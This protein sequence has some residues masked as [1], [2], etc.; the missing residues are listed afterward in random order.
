MS[1]KAQILNDAL[2]RGASG[3]TAREMAA[4]GFKDQV[5]R[6]EVRSLLVGHH[7]TVTDRYRGGDRVLVLPLYATNGESNAVL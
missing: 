7:L 5:L 1:I 4:Y 3:I 2:E 6:K